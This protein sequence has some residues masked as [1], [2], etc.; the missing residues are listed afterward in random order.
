MPEKTEV[1]TYTEKEPL[2]TS[3]HN[4]NHDIFVV[5]TLEGADKE[6]QWNGSIGAL[7]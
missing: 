6:D 3:R 2:F 5:T 7:V 4:P 1:I